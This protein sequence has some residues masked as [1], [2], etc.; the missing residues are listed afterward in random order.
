MHLLYLLVA[1]LFIG[2]VDTPLA[3]AMEITTAA[4]DS[5]PKY[6]MAKNGE[7]A[8]ICVDIIHAIEEVDPGLRFSGYGQFKPFKRLQM[9]LARGGIDIFFGFRKTPARKKKF[10]F[11]DI[12]LYTI[13]YVV[14]ARSD[15]AVEMRNVGDL[16]KLSAHGKVL[17]VFASA[18]SGFLEK[19][20]GLVFES[21]AKSPTALLKMLLVGRGRFAFYHD[22]GLRYIIGKEGLGEKIRITR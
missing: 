21:G 18:A 14:A 1:A 20:N 4:Q 13:N 10:I 6:Y 3:A 9:S 19:Q 12:P 5:P 17:T 16:R 2:Q 8:G 15:D 7:V 11:V 22:L